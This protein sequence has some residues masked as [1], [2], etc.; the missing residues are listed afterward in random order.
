MKSKKKQI[1]E[2]IYGINPLIELLKAKRRKLLALY[3]TKPI[4]EAWKKIE[5]LLPKYPVAIQYV[6]QR[7]VLHRMAGSTDHQ[8]IIAF[9]QPYVFRSKIFDPQKYPLLIM[10]DGIQDPRNLGAI[11]RSVYCTGFHGV[12]LSKKDSAPLNATAIKASAGLAE[13]IEIYLVSSASVA[14][15]EL[16]KAGYQLYLATFDGDNA[17]DIAFSTPLCVVIGSEGS[18]ISKNILSL[19]THITLPQRSADISYNASVAAGILLFLVST[20]NKRI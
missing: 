17:L 8:G 7:E 12:I 4:P 20:Q 10:L 19:G 5:P 15:Q 6:N 3:I 9:A 16:K 11:I 14:A 18:G 13:H 2:L 1:G